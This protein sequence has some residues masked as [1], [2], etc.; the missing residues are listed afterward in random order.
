MPIATVD[1]RENVARAY[2]VSAT[3]AAL[4]TSAPSGSTPGT[5]VTTTGSPAYAR[6]LITWANGGV[7]GSITA[8]VTFDVPTGTTVRGAGVHTAL[9][10]GTYLDGGTVPDQPY[11]SQGTYTLTLTH[12][13]T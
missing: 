2:G 5:E 6:K 4:Y 9:T 7:D 8:T 1:Q 10:G 3:H 11:T 13:Q 12:T